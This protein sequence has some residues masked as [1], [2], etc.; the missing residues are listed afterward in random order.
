M[1]SLAPSPTPKGDKREEDVIKC[2]KSNETSKNAVSVK[3]KWIDSIKGRLENVFF[4]KHS[5]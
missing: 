1:R 2:Y 4:M 5:W 3:T